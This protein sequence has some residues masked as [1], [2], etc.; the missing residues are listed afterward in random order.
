MY[1][2]RIAASAA[3]SRVGAASPHVVQYPAD[4]HASLLK[5]LDDVPKA[6]NIA[7]LSG[8]TDLLRA[9][10]PCAWRIARRRSA[11]AAQAQSSGLIY[12]R[13]RAMWAHLHPDPH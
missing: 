3:R 4:I 7:H 13:A 11:S 6:W 10:M 1:W 9:M 12:A 5:A 8:E 2:A